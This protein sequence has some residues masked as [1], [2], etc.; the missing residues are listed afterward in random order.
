MSVVVV[1]MKPEDR[2]RLNIDRLLEAA[3]WVVQD[4]KDL[5]LGAG[6]GVV[7]RGF[8]L[9]TGEAD[10]AVFVDRKAVGIIEAK[11]EGTTLGGVSEQTEKYLWGLADNVPSVSKPLRFAYESTGVETFFR[12]LRDPE[13]RSR[14][15]FAFHKP[16]TLQEWLGQENTLRAR[17]R[18]MPPLITEGLRTC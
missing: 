5:N 9:K 4:Y 7:V 15:V 18:T 2:A 12:D 16:E 8:P 14:R 6:L 11:P 1:A 10:Y 17:L 3:G 13:S